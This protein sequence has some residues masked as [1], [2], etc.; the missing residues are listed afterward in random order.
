LGASPSQEQGASI[1]CA[2]SRPR[3]LWA[4]RLDRQKRFDL[5]I[6]IAAAM[7]DVDF[8]C[9]GKAV[10]DAPPNLS[11]LPANVRMQGAFASFD[12]LPLGEAEGFLY[13]SAWDGLPTI[14][15][16]LGALGVPIVA[17]A[18]G[19]VPELID[20]ACGWP[21]PGDAGRE[22]Y[23]AALRD[24]LALPRRGTRAPRSCSARSPR[25]MDGR[26]TRRLSP[27]SSAATRWREVNAMPNPDISII[28]TGHREGLL[29]GPSAASARAA[30]RQAEASGLRV[31]T[32]RRSRSR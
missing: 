13:T 20:E 6:D 11:A 31:E 22:A 1:P 8:L 12:D 25:S 7:P 27:G 15:I 9:W 16:E 30:Q 29:A 32:H 5:L 28:V 21:V 17:S 24:L 19:G 3:I 10:L 4:G 14:L 18:V 2:D 23:V 26:A